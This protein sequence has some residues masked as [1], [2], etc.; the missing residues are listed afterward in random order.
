MHNASASLYA[1]YPSLWAT[2]LRME[3]ASTPAHE[4]VFALT[5]SRVFPR[6]F[7]R[8]TT[9]FE[10]GVVRGRAEFVLRKG[11][12][13]REVAGFGLILDEAAY[14]A[15]RRRVRGIGTEEGVRTWAD[16]WF[17]KVT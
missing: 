8:D 5:L 3:P 14:A 17:E 4:D 16:A 2:H 7:G 9:P 13:G 6:G 15:R 12:G 11:V 10:T 1:A